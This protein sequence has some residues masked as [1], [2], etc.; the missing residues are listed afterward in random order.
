MNIKSNLIQS[1]YTLDKTTN[2]WSQSHYAD[3]TYSDGDDTEERIAQIVAQASDVGLF[4]TELKQNC[5]DWASQ[6]HLSGVRANILR[7]FDF[8]FDGAD[9]LEI[10]AGCGA[11]TRFL[12]EANANVVAL[13]GT[14]RR[15]A[16]A[17]SR[18]RDLTNVEVVAER[19][20]EFSP[21]QKFDVITL[22][23]VLE[24][25]NQFEPNVPHALEMVRRARQLLKPTGKLIVA[26]ENQLGLKYFAGAP[27][28]HLGKVM[29]GLEDRYQTAEPQ[30][31]GRKVLSDILSNA[32][33][34][35][36][37]FLAPFPDYKFPVSIITQN[38]LAH[39]S[40]N[41]GALASQS[42]TLDV[43]L[44]SSLV[45]SPELVWPVVDS[46]GLTIDLS[47]SFLVVAH[48]TKKDVVSDSIL[49]YHYST[50][51]A[52]DYCKTSTFTI[53]ADESIL[54]K[55]Q[56]LGDRA[57][58]RISQKIQWVLP[59]EDNYR[60]G[61]L[62]SEELIGIITRDGWSIAEVGSFL[63][64]YLSSVNLITTGELPI[65]API[66]V[67]D[68]LPGQAFDLVPQNIIVTSAGTRAIDK[69]WSLSWDMNVGW[70]VYRT[71]LL[72]VQSTTCFAR[73]SDEFEWTRMGFFLAAF[74]SAGLDVSERRIHEFSAMEAEIQSEVSQLPL[75]NF[76]E[77]WSSSPLPGPHLHD[78]VAE[79]ETLRV[80]TTELKA[81]VADKV[82]SLER[83]K[84]QISSLQEILQQSELRI[85]QLDN[86]I[87]ELHNRD[88]EVSD[89]KRIVTNLQRE[90][91]ELRS[92]LNSV[93]S[94]SSWKITRIL[95]STTTFYRKARSLVRV[96]PA[97]IDRGGGL[98]PTVG[99]GARILLKEGLPGVKFRVRRFFSSRQALPQ[100]PTLDEKLYSIVPFY[101]DPNLDAKAP[102]FAFS[103]SLGVHLHLYYLDMLPEFTAHLNNIPFGYDLFVSVPEGTE[104]EPIYKA[105]QTHLSN[106][107]QIVIEPV[108]NR[109][110]DIAP[111]I[112]QFGE[113]LS[114]YDIVGHFHTKK[115]PH[116]G[117]LQHWCK[118]ILEKLLGSPN[119]TGGKVAY[120]V[121][122]LQ[123]DA[124]LVYPEG[125]TELLQD[126]TGW[127]ENFDL[128]KW[129]LDKYTT[130]SINDYSGVAFPEGSM[131]WARTE[132]IKEFLTLPLGFDE[133]PSEP[134]APDGTLAHALERL[135][136][137]FASQ[138]AGRALRIHT[139]DSIKDY[140]NYESQVDFSDRIVHSEI[141]VL[142]YYLPQFHP[143][144]ENDEWHGKGFTEWTKVRA[145]NPL[146][147]GHYQ[148]HI[149]HSDIGYYLLDSPEVLRTQAE[150]MRRA[151]VHGQV[152]YHYWFGGKLILEEPAQVLLANSDIQMPFSFCWANENW[153]RRWD[154]NDSDVLL[155]Q[156][157]SADDAKAFI[158]YL[159]PFFRDRRYIRIDD[160]PVL[161]IYR[162][163]SI[164][165]VGQYLEIWRRECRE[166]G[167]KEPYVVGV[168]TRGATDPSAYG[169]DAGVERVLHD[170]TDGSV[171]EL[172]HSLRPYSPINGS[173][174]SYVDVARFYAQQQDSKDFTYFRSLVPMWDNT[175]RY[176]SEAYVIHDSKPQFFQEWL[177][178][179]IDYTKRSLPLD[180]RLIL[181]NAWNE[182]AEGAHLEPD[183]RFG[184]SYLN[185][186]GR[187]LSGIPY[188][189]TL[190]IEDGDVAGA[191]IHISLPLHLVD[192]LERDLV[193]KKRF[194]SC[195]AKSSIFLNCFVTIDSAALL[196]DLPKAKLGP[197]NPDYIVEFRKI[198]L[199]DSDTIAKMVRTAQ[200]STATVLANGYDGNSPLVDI[201][202]NGS[203]DGSV[204]YNT[205]IVVVPKSSLNLGYRNFRMRT[206]ARCFV[207]SP[208]TRAESHKPTV[209]TIIRFHKAGNFSELKNALYCLY[210]MVDCVVVPFIAAQDLSVDQVEELESLLAEFEWAEG[211][212]PIVQHFKSSDGNGDLR[213]RML[214]ESLKL[215]KTQYAA[216]LD[217]DDLLMSHAYSWLISRLEL[218]G[219]A[220][221]FGRV[222]HTLYNSED[223]Y[224][225]ERRRGFEYG[226]SHAD[227]V[228]NNHAPLHSFLMDIEQID[229]GS[230]KYH[231][232]QRFMEDY[233]LTLQVFKE[234]NCDW[235]SLSKNMYIGDY[236]HATDRAHTLAFSNDE[237]REAL[238]AN[239]E[240]ILCDR[241]INDIRREISK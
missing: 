57:N 152:F 69:E 85:S 208:S 135:I 128:A 158:H 120:I 100:L 163:A 137:I 21:A 218:T 185:S 96:L 87:S 74:R 217:F 37:E 20:D 61:T 101:I 88:V 51:R 3:I 190:N 124:K 102:T 176:G 230:V 198:A 206:D 50:S 39:P 46:N 113:R 209:T 191:S 45:F 154:G 139:A 36:I 184:Y 112:V 174:L 91:E 49:G 159:I 136:L 6:Y 231:D 110:R 27:E 179:T 219:K 43:Q 235:N 181:V 239:E 196:V 175:A 197:N 34:E 4:S 138:H 19:F 240:Y 213:S 14:S 200:S 202:G 83:R 7:P 157:Y 66:S 23:G 28:D 215:V 149:P 123:S 25:A 70:L 11:I 90:A 220:V 226:Y 60:S 182:W 146:F 192:Q 183:T 72:L 165:N 9:V 188:N 180:R 35:R 47:N 76:V 211:F 187:A 156:N 71:L 12:G 160:R 24:Y 130:L 238:L 151:G 221:S 15:A 29:Y 68:K 16:I 119:S 161:F 236:I 204:A 212:P 92:S 171:P 106:A 80:E 214:N 145:A 173:V 125:R 38:G 109:G 81:E 67:D 10:G 89:L 99:K 104:V 2:V 222:Y 140:R 1:G 73:S 84:A 111:L 133:F 166:A 132:C 95:R 31:F 117:R 42:V 126:P 8:L 56:P 63:K 186:V 195:L 193:L 225:V 40:F 134:I 169:M 79:V 114:R 141:K 82:N 164:T 30:T 227:F 237:D 216:F 201:T 122:L 78:Q 118:D 53:S 234:D 207:S 129:V 228:S 17:R 32:E 131:F 116:S 108:P 86:V 55:Y 5:T 172:K 98:L 155:G 143:I 62:L 48:N 105:L 162:P 115:S 167:I 75:E 44:P 18:T 103:G 33:F 233:L 223:Q 177:E 59:E 170:W 241:R 58:S 199:F 54:V 13:E 22:I 203:I 148:Q 41:A 210:A 144:P 168:I 121:Q 142:S 224:L 205:P 153:T 52:V 93:Y 26:I 127:A 64:N 65:D 97:M 232:D 147:E 229:L 194:L 189:A 107:K 150:Q 178:N 77:W 94:S